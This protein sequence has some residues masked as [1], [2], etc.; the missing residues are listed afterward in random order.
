MGWALSSFAP[1]SVIILSKKERKE[2]EST[3]RK[4]TSPQRDVLRANI[5]L[6]AAD[7]VSNYGIARELRCASNTVRTWRRRFAEKRVDGLRDDERS[8]RPRIYDDQVRATVK[9]IA[10]ERPSQLGLPLSRLS[11]K[12]IRRAAEPLLKRTPGTTTIQGWLSA[13]AIRP[14]YR[15]SWI[16]PRDPQF[17]EKAAPILDLYHGLWKGKR[18][19]DSDVILSIDEK[20]VKMVTRRVEPPAAGKTVRYEFEYRRHGVA[21]YIAALD[22]RTGKASGIV[23]KSCT[24]K[25]FRSFVTQLM[26]R[27]RKGGRLFLIMDN[28][29]AHKPSTFTEWIGR[30]RG[31]TAVFTPVHASWLNQVEI[32]F[33]ITG[34]K[35]LTPMNIGGIGELTERLSCFEAYY[36]SSAGPFDWKFGRKDMKRVLSKLAA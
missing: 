5:V 19:D 17:A 10:C 29:T 11:L 15:R 6:L 33:S 4:S 2:L 7:G 35:A 26:R 32:Y 25:V 34:K 22:V 27:K 3:V 9:A 8:G 23:V 16:F 14:W 28:G 13:D 12:D 18:L 1:K 31:C 20:P 36:N 24:K 21:T 30:H